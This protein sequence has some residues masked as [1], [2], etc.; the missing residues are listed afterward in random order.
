MTD[1]HLVPNYARIR[2][3]VC[4]ARRFVFTYRWQ[5]SEKEFSTV[6]STKMINGVSRRLASTNYLRDGEH[7][8]GFIRFWCL[9]V[10]SLNA[11][12][13]DVLLLETQGRFNYV[14][15]RNSVKQ[16]INGR[17]GRYVEI[18]Q[19]H[20]PPPPPPLPPLE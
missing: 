20:S 16:K 13:G 19:H 17:N 10:H 3:S 15:E 1:S 6:C 18:F 14:D 7:V 4:V 2:I 11:K 5:C 9:I 12:T 8:R